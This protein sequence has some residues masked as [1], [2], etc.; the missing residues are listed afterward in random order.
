M[1]TKKRKQIPLKTNYTYVKTV[2]SKSNYNEF[3]ES[4]GNLKR[5]MD[6]SV[7]SHWDCT[8]NIMIFN[9]LLRICYVS[10]KVTM[11]CTVRPCYSV[12]YRHG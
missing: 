10:T 11:Y 6:V 4:G 7:Y 1:Y 2:S 8:G 12:T 3:L 5:G 9:T